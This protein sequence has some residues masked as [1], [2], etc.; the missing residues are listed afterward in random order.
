MPILV[1]EIKEGA[2]FKTLLHVFLREATF[3]LASHMRSSVQTGK[4]ADGHYGEKPTKINTAL[5]TLYFKDS[6]V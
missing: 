6:S 1:W 5:S 2:F 4:Q 3:F